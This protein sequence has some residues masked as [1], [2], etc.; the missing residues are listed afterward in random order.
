MARLRA[1][2][3]A[4]TGEGRDAGS[5]KESDGDGEGGR[6][7]G[8]RDVTPFLTAVVD[9]DPDEE[10]AVLTWAQSLDLELERYSAEWLELGTTA[11][12]DG[13]SPPG[14]G[15][16]GARPLQYTRQAELLARASARARE[17]GIAL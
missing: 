5:G 13:R 6:P 8:V 1:A 9:P 14:D 2:Y 7:E 12:A 11:E 17:A 16:G 4:V 10:A 3:A 15:A